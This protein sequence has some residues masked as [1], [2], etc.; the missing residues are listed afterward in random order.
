MNRWLAV[1]FGSC[2]LA[3]GCEAPPAKLQETELPIV[4]VAPPVQKMVT[5]TENFDGRT[6]AVDSVEVRARVSGYL[7]KVAFKPGSEVKKDDLLYE[8]D[9]RPYQTEVDQA[10]ANVSRAEA[11][12][13]KAQA[14]YDRSRRLQRMGTDAI[15]AEEV[16]RA[17]AMRDEATAAVA[18]NK[19]ALERAELNLNFTR[20][21]APVAGRISKTLVTE[22]NLVTADSTLLTTI[23][24]QAPIYATFE[25]PDRTVQRFQRLIREGRMTSARTQKDVP[26]LLGLP[27]E[28]GYPHPGTIDFVDNQVNPGTGTLKVR[29]IFPNEDGMLAPGLFVRIQLPIGKPRPA[30]LV[31][32]RVIGVDQG[33]KFVLVVQKDQAGKDVVDYRAIKTGERFDGLRVVEEGLKA[34]DR[35]IVLGMQRVRPGVAVTV[36]KGTMPTAAGTEQPKSPEATAP[37]QRSSPAAK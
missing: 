17:L 21:L 20:V 2:L 5:E 35:V 34:E 36:K 24:S 19:A 23:V 27:G 12:Q 6:E 11:A 10:K 13:K 28:I 15:S 4:T 26:V 14:E 7:D 33:Q 22:G 16:E 29:G 32:D 8:I 9:R 31:S 37:I 30:L 3:M 1:L 25:V 18:S